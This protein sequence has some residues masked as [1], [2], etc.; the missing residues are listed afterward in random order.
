M[1][2]NCATKPKLK[3]LTKPSPSAYNIIPAQ[4]QTRLKVKSVANFNNKAEPSLQ[5]K[6]SG[7]AIHSKPKT[8]LKQPSSGSRQQSPVV[9]SVKKKE[10]RQSN[11]QHSQ[12]V[13]SLAE[14][15]F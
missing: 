3:L 13:I 9:N 7:L 15:N 4:Q 10:N 2:Q 5:S 12:S 8:H 1:L 6:L 14:H 11:F